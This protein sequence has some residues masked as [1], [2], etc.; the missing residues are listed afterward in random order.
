MWIIKES[1]EQHV[2]FLYRLPVPLDAGNKFLYTKK[3]FGICNI[4][5]T[6]G[7]S[8]TGGE[9]HFRRMFSLAYE[10][11]KLHGRYKFRGRMEY[12]EN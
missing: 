10:T 8:G 1:T 5:N 7:H 11:G 9:Q 3:T 6:L 12:M 4:I 2:L